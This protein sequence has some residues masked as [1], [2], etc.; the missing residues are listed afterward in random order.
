M[1]VIAE[2]ILNQNDMVTRDYTKQCSSDRHGKQSGDLVHTKKKH[3]PIRDY[4]SVSFLQ[5][6]QKVK[7]LELKDVIQA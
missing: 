3:V 1:P 5:F 6:T 7:V 4:I 2:T